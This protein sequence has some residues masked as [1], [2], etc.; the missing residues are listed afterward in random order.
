MEDLLALVHAHLADPASGWSAGTV[1]ALAEFTRDPGEPA[2]IALDASGGRVVTAG[3]GLGVALAPGT[4]A[5]AYETPAA[6]ADAWNTAVAFVVPGR[7]AARATVLAEIGP[8][9]GALRP[10]DRDAILFDIGVPRAAFCVRTKDAALIATLRAATGELLLTAEHPAMAAIKAASPDRVVIT[11]LARIEV[12]QPIPAPGRATPAGPHTHLLPALLGRRRSPDVPL[13][14]RAAIGLTLHPASPIRDPDG[15]PRPFDGRAFAAFETLL[16]KHGRGA[17]VAEKARARAALE[18]GTAAAAFAPGP[19]RLARLAVRI[20]VRQ[21]R[22][23]AGEDRADWRA[24]FDRG[25]RRRAPG[26]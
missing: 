11:A 20:A 2:E 13:P 4:E 12:Y 3:G 26:H 14:P 5:I 17:Y 9:R 6:R 21:H 22:H 1:G 10:E 19:S 16:G 15:R 8:D 25:P 23:L 18:A 24:R 7:R